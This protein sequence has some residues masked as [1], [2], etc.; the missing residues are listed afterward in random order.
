L[1]FAQHAATGKKDMAA[2][3]KA[4]LAAHSGKGGGNKDFVRAKLADVA[5]SPAVLDFAKSLAS[6]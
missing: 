5:A 2:I 6:A 1:V 3:L 4:V